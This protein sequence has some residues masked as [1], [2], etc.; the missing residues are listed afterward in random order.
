MKSIKLWRFEFIVS[1]QWGREERESTHNDIDILYFDF[2]C[3]REDIQI[4]ICILGVAAGIK[5]NTR[6]VQ[7]D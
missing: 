5:F 4:N 3:C 2:S 6:E 7:D 1:S